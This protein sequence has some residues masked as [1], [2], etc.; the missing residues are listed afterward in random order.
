M[1][2]HRTDARGSLKLLFTDPLVEGWKSE[3]V[4]YELA[5]KE[6]CGLNVRFEESAVKG[7]QL[8]T[9]PDEGQS[10]YI[11]LAGKIALKDLR[12]LDLKKDDLFICRDVALMMK[13]RRI[14]RCSAG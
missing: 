7:V 6:G 14:W 8:V 9:D 10:F 3:N 12:P 2:A 5:L 13:R 11:I 1:S 4:I